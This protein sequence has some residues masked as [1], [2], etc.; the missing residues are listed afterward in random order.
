MNKKAIA[1]EFLLAL[2]IGILIYG[3]TAVVISKFFRLSDAAVDSFNGLAEQ[4]NS[5]KDR[6][7]EE[8][9][10]YTL[11][12]DKDTMIVVFNGGFSSL[13]LSIEPVGA[14]TPILSIQRPDSCDMHKPCICLIQ[15]FAGKL[16]TELVAYEEEQRQPSISIDYTKST[17][18]EL[19]LSIKY[20]SNSKGVIIRTNDIGLGTMN[21][22]KADVRERA[23]YTERG[24]GNPKKGDTLYFGLCEKT[25]CLS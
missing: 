2:V 14:R 1:L 20:I 12:M 19:D 23:V 22:I 4:I 8:V 21:S 11:V 24:E 13:S 10:A 25:P 3:T 7:K 15:E 18:R 6:T 16:K 17:C 9:E 5:M